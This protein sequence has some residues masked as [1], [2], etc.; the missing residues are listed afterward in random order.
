MGHG[1]LEEN[2]VKFKLARGRGEWKCGGG[3]ESSEHVID[4]CERNDRVQTKMRVKEII[5]TSVQLGRVGKMDEGY[6]G[7]AVR[8]TRSEEKVL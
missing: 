4:V 1:N 3:V 5:W 6:K 2:L 7:R 8:P